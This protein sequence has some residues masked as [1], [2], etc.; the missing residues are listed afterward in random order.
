VAR[1]GAIV[2]LGRGGKA[3]MRAFE[4]RGCLKDKRLEL[5]TDVRPYD[6]CDRVYKCVEN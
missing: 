5:K 4:E 2:G 1:R 3:L 6:M